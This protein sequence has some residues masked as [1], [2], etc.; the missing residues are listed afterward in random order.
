MFDLEFL[1]LCMKEEKNQNTLIV[2]TNK[3]KTFKCKMFHPPKLKALFSGS[4]E[5]VH[6]L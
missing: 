4:Q 1:S 5:A 2:K 6:V 3:P